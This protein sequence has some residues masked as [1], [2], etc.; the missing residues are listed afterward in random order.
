M[1]IFPI[2]ILESNDQTIKSNIEKILKVMLLV[3]LFIN[4]ITVDGYAAL[5]NCMPVARASVIYY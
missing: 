4:P 2:L 3:I 5:F 1:E